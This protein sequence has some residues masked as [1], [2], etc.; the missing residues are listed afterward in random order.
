MSV[1]P[2]ILLGRCGCAAS[3]SASN[4][5]RL[6]DSTGARPPGATM[7]SIA[8]DLLFLVITEPGIVPSKTPFR[9]GRGMRRT[10]LMLGHLISSRVE[11]LVKLG[12]YLSW[13]TA[14]RYGAQPCKRISDIL[15]C[16]YFADARD[17]FAWHPCHARYGCSLGPIRRRRCRNI[18]RTRCPASVSAVRKDGSS[19]SARL[20]L[21]FD[22]LVGPQPID[23]TPSG[24]LDIK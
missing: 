24:S 13:R 3:V 10:A 15:I 1:Q 16:V 20:L 23:G 12:N 21:T 4:R 17:A 22:Q 5:R 2:L 19:Q 11:R 8:K 9:H 6:R 18:S 7:F 14:A